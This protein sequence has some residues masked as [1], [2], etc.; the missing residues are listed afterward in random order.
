MDVLDEKQNGGPS[1][2]VDEVVSVRDGELNPCLHFS[3]PNFMLCASFRR[4][5]CRKAHA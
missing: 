5:V 4:G 3:S 2:E 1:M